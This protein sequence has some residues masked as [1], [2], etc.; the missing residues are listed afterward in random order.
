MLADCYKY[1]FGM[2]YLWQLSFMPLLPRDQDRLCEDIHWL[3]RV[4]NS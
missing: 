1:F 4:L 3:T 2:F